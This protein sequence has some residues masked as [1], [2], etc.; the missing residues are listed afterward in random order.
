VQV[1]LIQEELQRFSLRAVVSTVQDW[2]CIQPQLA[3]A[4]RTV[5][6]QHISLRVERVATI[7]AE[8]SGKVRAIISHCTKGSE[9]V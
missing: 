6:G 3:D 5:L 2:L 1:Q 7:P 4:L 9:S 8:P